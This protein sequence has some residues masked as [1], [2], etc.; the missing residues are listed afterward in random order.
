MSDLGL[1]AISRAG[2]PDFPGASYQEKLAN[3]RAAALAALQKYVPAMTFDPGGADTVLRQVEAWE[4]RNAAALEA[5]FNDP[6]ME[7]L[8]NDIALSLSPATAQA[9]IVAC[10]TRAAYGLGPWGSSLITTVSPTFA[11]A[12]AETRLQVFGGI[13][14]MDNDG[15]LAQ[16]YA[17]P[18]S[19]SGFG[20]APLGFLVIAVVALAAILAV[21][22][23]ANKRLDAN[24]RVMAEL[25]K[26]AQAQGDQAAIDKCIDATKDLQ[27]AGLFPGF[28]TGLGTVVGLAAILGLVWLGWQFLP[29]GAGERARA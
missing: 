9:F 2:L 25:C 17:P 15:F 19:T 5:A 11:Q 22:L 10:Y 7:T 27:M 21:Y 24:N 14:Q 1:L 8:T 13:V 20:L 3:G 6:S 26:T 29:R 18:Q 28:G 16:L 4:D 23:Y 12:D